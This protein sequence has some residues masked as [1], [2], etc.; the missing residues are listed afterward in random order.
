MHSQQLAI[1]HK[2]AIVSQLSALMP[3]CMQVNEEKAALES[4]LSSEQEYLDN[5]LQKKVCRMS[6]VMSV[7]ITSS[8]QSADCTYQHAVDE[9]AKHQAVG[10]GPSTCEH[11]KYSVACMHH[12]GSQLCFTVLGEHRLPAAQHR[13]QCSL[14]PCTHCNGQQQQWVFMCS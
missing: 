8:A 10:T 11:D 1:P 6:L 2:P 7:H 9:A 14:L 5:Q 3:A 13:T 4:R 12:A